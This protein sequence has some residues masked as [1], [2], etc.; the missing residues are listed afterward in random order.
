MIN[1]EDIL[2]TTKDNPF[3]PFTE[4][5][6][7]RAFD[8]DFSHPYNTEAYYMRE[9]GM[10]D[11]DNFSSKMVSLELA[12]IFEEIININNEMG[13]EIYEIITRD[14]KRLGHIPE[15]LRAD[16]N[17]FKYAQD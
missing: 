14:G 16:K 10:R 6:N 4:E 17:P 15:E 9:L 2:L 3:N 11:P 13:I 8:T 7:W 12:Q 5:D 1:A